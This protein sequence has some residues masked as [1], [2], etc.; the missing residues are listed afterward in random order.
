M[1][2]LRKHSFIHSEVNNGMAKTLAAEGNIVTIPW[3]TTI[4]PLLTH[5]HILAYRFDQIKIYKNWHI[6]KNAIN[7]IIII[8]K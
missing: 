4:L 7:I 5:L 3:K 1:E 6:I 8:I 2:Q